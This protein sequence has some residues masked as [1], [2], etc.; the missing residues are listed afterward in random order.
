MK[1]L[2]ISRLAVCLCFGLLTTGSAFSCEITGKVLAVK[3]H[4]DYHL[5]FQLDNENWY[6]F[7]SSLQWSSG[8]AAHKM[9]MAAVLSGNKVKGIN[10]GANCWTVKSLI[11]EASL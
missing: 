9:L 8:M 6:A 11:L 3:V 2:N 1:L 10:D 4:E 7:Y 5:S